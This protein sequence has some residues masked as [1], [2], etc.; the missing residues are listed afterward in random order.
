MIQSPYLS[1]RA[2]LTLGAASALPW[3]AAAQRP[4]AI[5]IG[6]LN[7]QSGPY[8]GPRRAGGDRV[9]APGPSSRSV[10]TQLQS[11]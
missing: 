5:R 4:A 2:A 9:R 11:I 8:Q 7:D 3:S 6:V 10:G 1:R